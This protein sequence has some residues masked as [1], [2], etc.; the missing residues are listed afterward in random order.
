MSFMRLFRR[1]IFTGFLATMLFGAVAV[2]APATVAPQVPPAVTPEET[3]HRA[4]PQVK[5]DS[6]RETD[7]KGLYE[8]VSGRN[9]LYYHAEK[10][11]LIFGEIFTR[12]GRNLTEERIGELAAELV[13]DLPLE[14]AV[15]IG[16]GK[17][18][19]IEFTDPDCDFCRTASKY[20]AGRTDV[21]RYVFFA[22]L[23]HPDAVAKIRY[24]LNAADKAQAYDEMFGGKGIPQNS[25][26]AGEDVIALAREHM[27]LA[28]KVGVRAT[29]T[30]FIN[31]R[32][33]V[34]ANIGRIEQLLKD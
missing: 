33:V 17:K 20:L 4:F 26:P 25:P 6:I 28:G 22:P 32:M 10:G 30:F 34:G 9:I 18:T 31:G 23:A 21:T 12:E 2:A 15:R 5:V 14:K 8:V 16:N 7:I 19:I 13:K 11:Y 1:T 24:I 3:F 27:A 29:P